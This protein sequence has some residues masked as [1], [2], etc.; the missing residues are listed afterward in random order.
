MKK[1]FSM[2]MVAL[3]A[4]LVAT[5]CEFSSGTTPNPNRANELLWQKVK[6]AMLEVNTSAKAVMHLNDIMLGRE[7][8]QTLYGSFVV[9]EN[10]GVY[11]IAYGTA[12][13]AYTTYRIVTGGVRLDEGGEWD[14]YLKY[15]SYMN[16]VKIGSAMGVADEANSFSIVVDSSGLNLCDYEY[17][18]ESNINYQYNEIVERL[19]VEYTNTKGAISNYLKAPNSYLIEF[20][21]LEPILYAYSIESGKVHILY[22]DIVENT[23]REVTVVASTDSTTFITE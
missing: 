9:E 14:I 23:K 2:F 13:Y 12:E 1:I 18:V 20:T 21:T 16:F 4:L 19:E 10:N 8:A 5:S 22:K 6:S 15:G 11:T 7:I 3:V 17:D